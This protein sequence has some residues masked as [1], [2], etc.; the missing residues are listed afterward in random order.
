MQTNGK[1]ETTDLKLAAFLYSKGVH[2]YG[3]SWANPQRA[4]FVFE[5]N[6]DV[7]AAW[8]KEDGKFIK[9]YE[10]SRNFLRDVLEGKINVR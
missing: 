2:F 10:D 9:K 4:V 1:F 8:L 6:D 3:L 7:L 5:T